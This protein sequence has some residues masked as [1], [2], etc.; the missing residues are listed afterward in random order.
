MTRCVDLCRDTRSNETLKEYVHDE[1]RGAQRRTRLMF[2]S[3]RGN[4]AGVLACLRVRANVSRRDARGKTALVW[5]CEGGHTDVVRALIAAGANIRDRD[6]DD[7]ATLLLACAGGHMDLVRML[8]NNGAHVN[9]SEEDDYAGYTP[10]CEAAGGGHE[11]L[12]RLLLDAGAD[13]DAKSVEGTALCWAAAGSHQALARELLARGAAVEVGGEAS[14]LAAAADGGLLDL[15]RDLVESHGAE[16]DGY[17]TD[18]REVTNDEPCTALWLAASKGYLEIVRYLADQGADIDAGAFSDESPLCVACILGHADVAKELL[19]RGACMYNRFGESVAD[20]AA[21]VSRI[22]L[23]PAI[24][25]LLGNAEI[26][27]Y[28]A[29][30]GDDADSGD[31]GSEA[32]ET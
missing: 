16:V 25:S 32:E 13:I 4:L 5:A 18:Y 26:E 1:P 29:E 11:E 12:V 27:H 23:S 8:I 31:Y 10:L 20:V 15:V 28:L 30:F 2:H 3:A 21:R 9:P 22:E 7:K 6:A 17:V 14:A 24:M 19:D